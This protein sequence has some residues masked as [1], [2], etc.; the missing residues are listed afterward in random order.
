M[1]NSSIKTT[2]RRSRDLAGIARWYAHRQSTAR[3]G[4]DWPL[5]AE[6]QPRD[7][8]YSAT[9]CPRTSAQVVRLMVAGGGH[10][11]AVRL[12]PFVAA[13]VRG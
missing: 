6:R 8:Q 12:L 13:V 9:A 3:T 4:L 2:P 10:L 5:A 7:A 11:W 1:E